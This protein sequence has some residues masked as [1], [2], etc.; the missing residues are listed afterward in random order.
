MITAK[1][2]KVSKEQLEIIKLKKEIYFVE[3]QNIEI[4]KVWYKKAQWIS[5]LSPII[6]GILTLIVAWSTGFLQAQAKLNEIQKADFLQKKDSIIKVITNLNTKALA[7]NDEINLLRNQKKQSE[8]L[9]DVFNNKLLSKEKKQ[10]FL[11]KQYILLQQENAHLKK[12]IIFLHSFV[13]TLRSIYKQDNSNIEKLL[14][15]ETLNKNIEELEYE[16]EEKNRVYDSLTK[17]NSSK[18]ETLKSIKKY[19]KQ[20]EH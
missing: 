13:K 8:T 9:R 7:L 3:K 10:K 15:I 1:K 14:E 17:S 11:L 19:Q 18:I 20:L 16:I 12:R 2:T 6:V 5:A 4:N